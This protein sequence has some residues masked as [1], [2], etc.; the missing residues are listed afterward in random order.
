MDSAIGWIPAL[1]AVI[2][3][4]AGL[5]VLWGSFQARLNALDKNHERI[6]ANA[7][8]IPTVEAQLRAI[9]AQVCALKDRVDYLYQQIGG[10]KWRGD[11]G[12]S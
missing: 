11:R 3:A 12:E 2:V 8:R 7:E 1:L 9:D 6:Q 5:A 10:M 4:L